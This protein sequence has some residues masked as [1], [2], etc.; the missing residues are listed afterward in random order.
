METKPCREEKNREETSYP[1]LSENQSKNPRISQAADI[2]V[3]LL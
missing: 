2:D 1:R 3:P